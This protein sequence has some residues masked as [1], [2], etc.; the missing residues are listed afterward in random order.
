MIP[1]FVQGRCPLAVP[2]ALHRRVGPERADHWLLDPQ[3]RDSSCHGSV[4]WME[5]APIT[6]E[7]VRGPTSRGGVIPRSVEDTKL[8]ARRFKMLPQ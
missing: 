3:A 2:Q 5:Y 4:C 1:L 8:L 7:H 6:R